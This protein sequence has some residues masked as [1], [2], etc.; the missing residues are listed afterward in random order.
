MI[1]TT[2]IVTPLLPGAVS[3]QAEATAR[4]QLRGSYLCCRRRSFLNARLSI[5]GS[6]AVTRASLLFIQEKAL[7]VGW[8]NIPLNQ[9][10]PVTQGTGERLCMPTRL[11]HRS[12]ID[13]ASYTGL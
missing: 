12:S 8:R 6:G 9:L 13:N 5:G 11:R 1:A 10:L 3:D 4:E 7:F 2:A